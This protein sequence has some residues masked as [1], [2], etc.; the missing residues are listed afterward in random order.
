MAGR[1]EPTRSRSQR[2]ADMWRSAHAQ[3]GWWTWADESGVTPWTDSHGHDVIPLWTS[4]QRATEES[5]GS[6]EEGVGPVFLGTGKLL[7]LVPRLLEAGVTE[8]G[9]Q[10]E[11]G[12]FLLT[13]EL[14]SLEEELACHRPG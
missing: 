4:A 9:L 6:A 14:A 10:S 2:L 13:V 1:T 5:R 7:A 11:G 3:G 8:A 12:R